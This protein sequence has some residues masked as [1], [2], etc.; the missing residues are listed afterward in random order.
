MLN[1]HQE[2][3][4]RQDKYLVC[5]VSFSIQPTNPYV[6]QELP[7]HPWPGTGPPWRISGPLNRRLGLFGCSSAAESGHAAAPGAPDR[8]SQPARQHRGLLGLDACLPTRHCLPCRPSA[9]VSFPQPSSCLKTLRFRSASPGYLHPEDSLGLF[10]TRLGLWCI[11]CCFFVAI[12]SLLQH[13]GSC[14]HV[15]P[16]PLRTRTT[17]GLTTPQQSLR[18]ATNSRRHFLA[19][20]MFGIAGIF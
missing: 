11:Y 18:A 10:W 13:L 1:S 2:P 8:Y 7:K 5:K 6:A 14:E 15:L 3:R 19:P 4:Y 17:T 16:A 12:S 9:T 20:N